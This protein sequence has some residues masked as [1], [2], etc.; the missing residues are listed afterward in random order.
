MGT[1]KALSEGYRKIKCLEEGNP[2]PTGSFEEIHA[3]LHQ[4]REMWEA[5]RGMMRRDLGIDDPANGPPPRRPA[6]QATEA[7]SNRMIGPLHHSLQHH[8]LFDE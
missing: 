7:S 3:D 8:K 1:A 5:M 4:L 6:G 2:V